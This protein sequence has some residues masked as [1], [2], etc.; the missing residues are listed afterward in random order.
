M[1]IQMNKSPNVRRMLPRMP[2]ACLKVWSGRQA[3]GV[4]VGVGVTVGVGVGNF[5][6]PITTCSELS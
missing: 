5:P 4:G 6:H 3:T 2:E 1:V